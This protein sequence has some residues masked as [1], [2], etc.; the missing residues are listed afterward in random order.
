M[1]VKYAGA[2][3]ATR[4]VQVRRPGSRKSSRAVVAFCHAPGRRWQRRRRSP[5]A[6]HRVAGRRESADPLHAG[7]A[8]QRAQSK[9]ARADHQGTLAHRA[10]LRKTSR[11]S[12]A[13]TTTRGAPS[14]VGITA[15]T[16][17]L[18][19][20]AFVTSERLRHLPPSRGRAR[21]R[22][23][24]DPRGMNATSRTPSSPRASP[25]PASS[26]D[27]YRAAPIVII[28]TLLHDQTSDSGSS[29]SAPPS[30][31][32]SASCGVT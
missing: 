20:Y 17:V 3:A 13:S 25:S 22:H 11:E 26:F 23:S 24:L 8:A 19:C 29:V 6:A 31:S 16:V 1:S 27:G 14:A 10:R 18:C 32:A 30:R 7:A 21:P 15:V 12:W 28:P 2:H 5:L 9:A 4:R